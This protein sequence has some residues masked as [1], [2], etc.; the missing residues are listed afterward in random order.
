MRICRFDNDRLGVVIGDR[1]HDVT[2]AQDEIRASAPYAMK[3][4]AVVAALPM[5]GTRLKDMA[6]AVPGKPLAD[7]ALL[8]PVARPGKV[9][10]APTN[11]KKHIEEMRS[12]R[13]AQVGGGS[14][15]PSDI[16]QAGIFLKSN[17]AVVGP[18]EGIPVRFPDRRNDHEIELVLIIG[19]E[20]SRIPRERALDHVAAYC[21]GLDMT[22]RGPQDRSFRKSCDGYAVLGP[23]MVTADEIADPDDLPLSL[24]VNDD[25][26]Q[27]TNTSNLIYDI[28]RLIEFASEYYTLY[29]GDVY[30]TGTPEGVGPVKPGDRL[31]GRSAAVLGELQIEV[32]A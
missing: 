25:L 7:V 32:R 18:S 12:V 30:Y 21:L 9:M 10:A 14:R 5:W 13:E 22:V 23:W 1:V 8:S 29:P 4:D 31:V 2:A 20:G 6:A 11:Y 19:R 3:G 16:G 15:F 17:T 26:R 27:D 24:H 28:R